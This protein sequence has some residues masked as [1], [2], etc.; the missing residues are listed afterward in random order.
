MTIKK[1]ILAAVTL[2]GLTLGLVAQ[3]KPTELK[4]RRISKAA[5]QVVEVYDKTLRWSL[6]FSGYLGVMLGV[7]ALLQG[8]P[9]EIIP[10]VVMPPL[11]VM[12]GAVVTMLP[13]LIIE[14]IAE[15]NL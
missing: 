10:A 3:A 6:K 11:I 8:K 13:M 9:E 1:T 4:S 14:D 5:A 12:A 7:K 15:S 2:T